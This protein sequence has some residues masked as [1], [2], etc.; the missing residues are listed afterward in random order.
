MLLSLCLK[1][2]IKKQILNEGCVGHNTIN[3]SDI[4]TGSKWNERLVF[5]CI[6][7]FLDARMQLRAGAVPVDAVRYNAALGHVVNFDSH[8]KTAQQ[9]VTRRE[10][11]IVQHACP[12]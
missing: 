12:E 8:V 4:G 7:D 11:S 5:S 1:F 9:S 2:I 3:I 10:S 6:F